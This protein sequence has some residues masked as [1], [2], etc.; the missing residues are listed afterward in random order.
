MCLGG[1]GGWDIAFG[2]LKPKK[3]QSDLNVH[4]FSLAFLSVH[5]LAIERGK[6]QEYNSEK[7]LEKG[8]LNQCE[9]RWEKKEKLQKGTSDT[10][11]DEKGFVSGSF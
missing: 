3:Y 4:I 10:A 11:E 1:V 7:R 5:W 9:E 2:C 8:K 6:K